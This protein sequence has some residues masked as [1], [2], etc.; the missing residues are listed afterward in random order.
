[1][2]FNNPKCRVLHLGHNNPMQCYR[3]GEEQLESCLAEKDLGVLVD[4]CLNMSQQCAQVAKKANS[5]LS[6]IRNSVASRTREVIVPLY[7]A[8]LS[9]RR[10]NYQLVAP[11]L[12]TGANSQELE[13]KEAQQLGSLAGDKAIDKGIGTGEAVL[14]LWRRLLSSVKDRANS[15]Q[16]EGKEAQQLGSLARNW[17]IDRGIGKEAA[18][19]SLWRQLLSSVRA[20]YPFKE[21]LVNYQG[22]WT[23]VDEG[24]Q[25]LGELVVLEVIYSDLDNEEVSKDPEDVL[26]TRA[27]WRKVIQ[28]APASY[29]INL[30]AMYCPD[31]D[32]PT[33]ERVSSWLQNF[34]K[35]LC[36]SSSPW[37]SA[38]AVWGAPRSQSPPALVRGKG[39]PRRM[40]HGILWFFLHDQG[41]DMRKWGGEPTFKLEA[42][43]HEL[44]GKT[45]VKKGATQEG[46]ECRP[47]FAFTWSGI[48]YTWNPLPQGWKH[49]PTICHGLIQ[50]ALEQGEALEH[51]QYSDVIIVWAKTVEEVFEKGRRIIQILLKAGFAINQTYEGIRAA[52]EVVGTEAQLHLAPQWP[53]LGW[54]FK[55]KVP[56]TH[57]G[58]DATWSKWVALIMQ[59][60]QM[61][62]PDCPGILE[63]IID[64]PEGRN[65]RVL[66]EEVTHAE[67]APLYNRLPENEKQYA[68]FTDGSCCI[69]GKHQR[70]KA[71]VWSPTQ[72]TET[73]KEKMNRANLQKLKPFSWL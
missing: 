14:S 30:A 62:N 10:A 70:W 31:M 6:C 52:S 66:P 51:L 40:L 60:A 46:S 72:V 32:T 38:L 13:G 55:G 8:L 64:W 54:M 42:C 27:M 63:V 71:S 12:D 67:E 1:M 61:E 15:Q 50:T 17:E 2:R 58:T 26:C 25:Y 29:S 19:C 18:I 57:H 68:L 53:V 45:A 16:L 11:M 33:V 35:N 9:S 4:S 56:S 47:Q 22:K 24:I 23:T 20:R 39:S 59:R 69:V 7:S 34:E 36:P 73:L 65:F 5:I 49:S 44:R 41:E 43:V 37:A 28:S 3:L 21:D 48:Q